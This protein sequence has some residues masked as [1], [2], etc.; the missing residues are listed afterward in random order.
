M[1]TDGALGLELARPCGPT[2]SA[3]L[4]PVGSSFPRKEP[5]VEALA[6]LVV[7]V[8]RTPI[9]AQPLMDSLLPRKARVLQR[10]LEPG[11]SWRF[12]CTIKRLP[13]VARRWLRSRRRLADGYAVSY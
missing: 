4:S 8:F 2:P 6:R 9:A 3:N 1:R 11:P 5:C 12:Y 13:F 7:R 10:T